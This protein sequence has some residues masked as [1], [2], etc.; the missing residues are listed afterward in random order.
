M[1]FKRNHKACF[2]GGGEFD[3]RTA[4]HKGLVDVELYRT[5]CGGH[6]ERFGNLKFASETEFS[7]YHSVESHCCASAAGCAEFDIAEFVFCLRG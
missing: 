4:G 5:V 6:R 1:P 3:G 2:S 7:D